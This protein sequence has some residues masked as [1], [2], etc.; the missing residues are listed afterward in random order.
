M[1]QH[2]RNI[3]INYYKNMAKELES[4]GAHILA[5]KDMAGLIKTRSCLSIDFGT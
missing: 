3:H 2:E 1:I 4:Q 5:I